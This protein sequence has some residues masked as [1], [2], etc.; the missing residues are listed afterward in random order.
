MPVPEQT[1]KDLFNHIKL[2]HLTLV[3]DLLLPNAP[4]NEQTKIDLTGDFTSDAFAKALNKSFVRSLAINHKL[5]DWIVRMEGMSG[6]KYRYFIN[7]LVSL[8]ENPIYLE[9]G[10]WAGSTACSA[11]F[12]NA[13]S[14]TCID[15]WSLFGGPKDFFLENIKRAAGDNCNFRFIES[16]FR[17]VNFQSLEPANI[18]LFDGPHTEDDQYD[19]I[20]LALPALQKKFI[21]IVDDY[22][23][24]EVRRGTQRAI[25]DAELKVTC[26]LEIR[27]TLDNTHPIVQRQNSDWHNGYFMAVV[28]KR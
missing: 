6:R 28:D 4:F 10:S 24:E 13:G 27:T 11:I 26:S 8:V 2:N 18:Y 23:W 20:V 22:N 1:L 5:P 21:L 16:D 25:V 7:N 12:G 3:K 9:V 19:G 14:A 15:N 17:A